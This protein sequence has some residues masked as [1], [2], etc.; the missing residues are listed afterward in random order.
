MGERVILL[1]DA[2]SRHLAATGTLFVVRPCKWQEC[3]NVI[4]LPAE[5]ALDGG[6]VMAFP[7]KTP[8]SW[9]FHNGI[10]IR[11]YEWTVDT[12]P[13]GAPGDV[14][15][16]KEAWGITDMFLLG[17]YALAEFNSGEPSAAYTGKIPGHYELDEF[18]DHVVY[19]AD[20][21]RPFYWRPAST[22]PLWAVRLRPTVIETGVMRVGEMTRDDCIAAGF[23]EHWTCLSPATAAYALDNDPEAEFAAD[24]NRRF[25]KYPYESGCWA[26]WALFKTPE[27]AERDEW[28]Q[29]EANERWAMEQDAWEDE[30]HV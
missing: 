24:W 29:R 3:G 28:A 30:Q 27:Q 17:K 7:G 16:C 19:R 2:E 6:G 23:R 15:L 4:P 21:N 10:P 11:D 25:R 18:K 22:M 9:L 5:V 8:D 12:N 14:L 26:W 1:S 13:L 20:R